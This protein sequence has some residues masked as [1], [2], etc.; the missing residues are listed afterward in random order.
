[1]EYNF[2]NKIAE[3]KTKEVYNDNGK[4]IKLFVENYSK[5]AIL[6][7]ALNQARVEETTDLN[8]PKLIAVENVNGRWAIVSE[9]AEGTPLDKL[10]EK[11]PEKADEYLNLFVNIQMEVLSKNVPLLS[12]IKDKFKRKLSEAQNINE[13][14]RFD[15]LHRLEGM[16]NHAKLCHGDFN[17]S[18]VIIAEDGSY[19]IIDWAHATQGNASADAARTYLIFSMQGKTE[20]AE[21]Y[22]KKFSEVSEIEISN[23]QRWIPI[24]AATQ[25]TKGNEDEQEFLKKWVDVVDYE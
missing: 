24:V 25:M 12:R 18:N 10:M 16:K 8:I 13:N 20:L 21:K 14:V 1:M 4:T 23:I 6:N 3:R 22:L 9:F 7:E 15:L 2:K 19:S 11:N 5:A 17:P